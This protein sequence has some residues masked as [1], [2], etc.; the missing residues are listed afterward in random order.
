M[1]L[2][3]SGYWS[4]RGGRD[5]I[6][7]CGHWN[8]CLVASNHI[9]VCVW[10]QLRCYLFAAVNKTRWNKICALFASK[11]L[12]QPSWLQFIS[13]TCPILVRERAWTV[14][15]LLKG[16]RMSVELEQM[17]HTK[18]AQ[19][20][21]CNAEVALPPLLNNTIM[22]FRN[23]KWL[24]CNHGPSHQCRHALSKHSQQALK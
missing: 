16:A 10:G 2:G 11:H 15:F 3:C 23:C 20:V 8:G 4:H 5:A 19:F 7:V 22:T 21:H 24:C 17:L 18:E 14:F 1:S 12:F 13:I 6:G 9:S